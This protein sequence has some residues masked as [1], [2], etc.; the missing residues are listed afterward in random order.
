M[1]C[2]RLVGAASTAVF[3]RN[4]LGIAKDWLDLTGKTKRSVTVTIGN[5]VVE[6]KQGDDLRAILRQHFPDDGTPN[7]L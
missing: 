5:T 3:V 1:T 7:P 4:V 2:S 6:I